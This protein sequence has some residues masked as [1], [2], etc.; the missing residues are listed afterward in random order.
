[1]FGT[2]DHSS[3]NIALTFAQPTCIDHLM[4]SIHST[5]DENPWNHWENAKNAM[6]RSQKKGIIIQYALERR[7][8]NQISSPDILACLKYFIPTH[9]TTTQTQDMT[10]VRM[11]SAG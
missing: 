7:K 2:R 5:Y 6:S 4:L 8:E 10:A 1:M 9:A 3:G 11:I